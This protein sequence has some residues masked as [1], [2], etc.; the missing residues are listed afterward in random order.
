MKHVSLFCKLEEHGVLYLQ[1]WRARSSLFANLKN[2]EFFIWKII[3]TRSCRLYVVLKAIISSMN[4]GKFLF[5]L[6]GLNPPSLPLQWAYTGFF[7]GWGVLIILNFPGGWGGELAVIPCRNLKFQI[8]PEY[9]PI[10][11]PLHPK[12]SISITIYL[13]SKE[14]NPG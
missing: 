3:G 6:P 8:S 14:C 13:L 1:T 2:T 9:A 12:S 7:R 5:N 11:A 4:S 10:L